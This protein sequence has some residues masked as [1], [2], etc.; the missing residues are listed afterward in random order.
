M[1]KKPFR[2]AK[3]SGVKKV[4]I[5]GCG[6]HQDPDV[7]LRTNHNAVCA[8]AEAIR[9]YINSDRTMLFAAPYTRANR[10]YLIGRFLKGELKLTIPN[11][12]ADS[13]WGTRPDTARAYLMDCWQSLESTGENLI[14]IANDCLAEHITR[15][16]ADEYEICRPVTQL[17][18]ENG[19]Y[20]HFADERQVTLYFAVF[21][22]GPKTLQF[23]IP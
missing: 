10:S 23:V 18:A 2:L 5:V 11:R 9:P 3:N 19:R 21:D 16:V 22:I 12:E 7:L 14:I 20:S 6:S 1:K 4:I 17:T 15:W 13:L 8:L